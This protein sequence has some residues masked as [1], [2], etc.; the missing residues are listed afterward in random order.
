RDFSGYLLN[1]AEVT[2]KSNGSWTAVAGIL[3]LYITYT[4]AERPKVENW[5][6]SKC[7][8]IQRRICYAF[9][10]AWLHCFH[11]WVCQYLYF[12]TA[13]CHA[14]FFGVAANVPRQ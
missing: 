1:F 2:R 9:V 12:E 3:P 8:D 14:F 6:F 11:I 5:H 4:F 13:S 7:G 10:I